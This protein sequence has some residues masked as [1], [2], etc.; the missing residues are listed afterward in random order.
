MRRTRGEIGL[1]FFL[2]EAR[3]LADGWEEAR[4]ELCAKAEPAFLA[5]DSALSPAFPAADDLLA[6]GFDVVGFADGFCPDSDE[7]ALFFTPASALAGGEAGGV[8]ACG[9]GVS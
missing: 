3:G 5:E 9:A 4:D 8:D 1:L 6:L 7:A 2:A